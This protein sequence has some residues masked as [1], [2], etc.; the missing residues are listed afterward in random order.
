MLIHWKI[1]NLILGGTQQG[2][3]GSSGR[4]GMKSDEFLYNVKLKENLIKIP[5]IGK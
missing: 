4:D 2:N 5:I 1:R 3:L